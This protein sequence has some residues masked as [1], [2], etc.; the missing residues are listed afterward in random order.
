VDKRTFDSFGRI[1]SETNPLVSFRY[2]Y[3][4]RERDLESGLDY[5]R[6]RYYDPNV[7]RFISVD[8]MGFEAGDTNLYRYVGNSSTNATDPSGEWINFAVGAFIGG[9]LDLT[10]QLIENKGDIWKTDLTRLAI[11]TAAGAIGGGI[12]G[13][14]GK[15]GALLKGVGL[16]TE[17]TLVDT[18]LGLGGRTLINAG[19]GFNLGYWGKVT[20][21][22]IGGKELFDG[23][24][25]T[26]I[27]GGAGAAAGELVQ[28]GIGAAWNKYT[29]LDRIGKS[30]DAMSAE[31]QKLIQE[32]DRALTNYHTP[33]PW[34]STSDV[35]PLGNHAGGFDPHPAPSNVPEGW[36]QLPDGSIVASPSRMLPSGNY[37]TSTGESIYRVQNPRVGSNI[38]NLAKPPQTLLDAIPS[39]YDRLRSMPGSQ[40]PGS[41]TIIYDIR[42]DRT[43]TGASG[44]PYPTRVSNLL[45]VIEKSQLHKGRS[46]VNCGE[47]KAFS[48]ALLNGSRP[49]DLHMYTFNIQGR[50]QR[51]INNM[52]PCLNCD[53]TFNKSLIGQG[54]NIWS[55][56]GKGK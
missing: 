7:G 56:D 27:A 51:T 16:F 21:N 1:L 45:P 8:P 5:Y 37:L 34:L 26:G 47:F 10:F 11:S 9:A 43:Y 41:G 38:N 15:G 19:V 30:L 39:F 18:G 2:G 17:H 50:N 55:W 54:V 44:S 20:E 33:D 12:G 25:F 29:R 52:A 46:Q 4:G 42:L 24:L 32:A 28:A 48:E 31:T 36:M 3:T 22:K 53:V 23:A 49:E 13:A 35:P 6:A 14:L 40:R